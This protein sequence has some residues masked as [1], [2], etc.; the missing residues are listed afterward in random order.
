GRKRLAD[1][2]RKLP[3]E[4][5]MV[6]VPSRVSRPS[7][8]VIRTT[9]AR[10]SC[11]GLSRRTGGVLTVNVVSMVTASAS[12]ARAAGGAPQNAKAIQA[13]KINADLSSSFAGKTGISIL[14][15]SGVSICVWPITRLL[16]V[17]TFRRSA[18]R[19]NDNWVKSRARRQIDL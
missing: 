13:P 16:R 12:A 2:I 18:K 3:V 19:L 10:P 8:P 9:L 1:G 15:N 14:Q 5:V 4:V 6:P 17:L 7:P 11:A